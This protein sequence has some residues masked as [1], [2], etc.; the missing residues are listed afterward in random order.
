MERCV[1]MTTSG[2]PVYAGITKEEL[3]LIATAMS[4]GLCE[5]KRHWRQCMKGHP[6]YVGDCGRPQEGSR[7]YECKV[8]IG[9]QDR[10]ID[11]A[12]KSVN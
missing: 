10:V 7:C 1:C 4:G 3:L 12:T 11:I 6:Y 9:I 8:P 2:D 5:G